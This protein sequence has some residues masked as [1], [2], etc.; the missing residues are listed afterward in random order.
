[1][2]YYPAFLDLE[3]KK[4]VV[5]GGGRVAERK[6]LTLLRAGAEVTVVSPALTERLQK[7]K[8]AK[9]IRQVPR[10]YRQ[11][12]L[13]GSFLVIAATDSPEVNKK[14]AGDAPGLLNVVDVPSECNFIAPSVVQRGPLVF[15]ISTGG[16]SPALAKTVRKEIEK[17]YGPVFAGYLAFV[18]SL[19]VRA[20]RE[21]PDKRKREQF[22]KGLA[23]EDIVGAL[24]TKGLDDVKQT[25]LKK[26]L[27]LTGG[28]Q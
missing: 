17:A 19:R 4:A 1:M 21:I 14:V 22:L 15:A 24:R 13:D 6:V 20:M 28:K 3:G 11:G 10:S 12:D 25:V 27:K 9:R 23:S 7:E 8:E 2:N 16:T 26:F 5:V 18:K